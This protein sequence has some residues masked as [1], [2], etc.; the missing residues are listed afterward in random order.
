MEK[1]DIV[2]PKSAVFDSTSIRYAE[3]TSDLKLVRNSL[4]NRELQTS[5]VKTYVPFM[6]ALAFAEVWVNRLAFELFFDLIHS[7]HCS[8]Q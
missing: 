8:W 3:V 6:L 5:F 4:N 2:G 7:Y 1:A